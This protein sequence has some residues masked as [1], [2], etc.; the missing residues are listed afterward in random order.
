M[1]NGT[2]FSSMFDSAEAFNQEIRGWEVDENADLDSMFKEAH[3]IQSEYGFSNTPVYSDF[4]IVNSG[5]AE[6]SIDGTP[7]IF[8]TLSIVEDNADPDGT[9]E[10]TYSWQIFNDDSTWEE[11]G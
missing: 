9:G 2:D 7:K 10:L 11:V 6:F 1:Y 3:L 8:E 5:E 4:N